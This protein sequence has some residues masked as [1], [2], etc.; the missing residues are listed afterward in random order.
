MQRSD[1]RILVQAACDKR[2]LAQAGDEGFGV[3]R[4]EQHVQ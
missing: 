1:H 4:R 2:C 3:P